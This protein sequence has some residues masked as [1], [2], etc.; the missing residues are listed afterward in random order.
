MIDA[1]S[2][3]TGFSR[4]IEKHFKANSV[5]DTL[6]IYKGVAIF[7]NKSMGN[8]SG[9][10]LASD[11]YNFGLKWQCVE[12]VKRYYYDRL[13]HKMPNSYGNA[14]DFFNEK[15]NDGQLNLDRKLLQ[16][17][18]GSHSKPAV[19]DI[20][21]FDGNILN[22]YG[23]VAIISKV[24]G[25]AIEIVQQNVGK[26]SRDHLTLRFKNKKWTFKDSS[27]LGWLRKSD[28]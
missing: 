26:N 8:T 17:T 25:N 11:G 16:F 23:H 27:I 12:F 5:G 14:K 7:Y 4:K 21:I 1:N 10:N 13:N 3:D 18:N 6:D 2:D 28:Q 20:I 24:E 9:R 19:D 22:P 15:L